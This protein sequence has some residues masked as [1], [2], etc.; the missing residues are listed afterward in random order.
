M[1]PKLFKELNDSTSDVPAYQ[2]FQRQDSGNCYLRKDLKGVKESHFK[3]NYM[4]ELKKPAEMMKQVAYENKP[5]DC[6]NFY[7]MKYFLTENVKQQTREQNQKTPKVVDNGL[8]AE[9]K[10]SK[11]DETIREYLNDGNLIA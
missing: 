11:I 6:N 3:K 8:E 5:L 4:K 7:E 1:Y 10:V 2:R 9:K